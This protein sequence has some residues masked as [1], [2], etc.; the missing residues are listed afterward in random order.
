M[1]KIDRE[2][3]NKITYFFIM[4]LLSSCSN[5]QLNT[6][7][8]EVSFLNEKKNIYETAKP[9][10]PIIKDDSENTYILDTFNVFVS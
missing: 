8:V 7:N 9:I 1:D 4:V 5:K 2:M 10:S 6:D 3:K